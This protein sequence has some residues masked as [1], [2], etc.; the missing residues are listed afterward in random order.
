MK[1][2]SPRIKSS[3]IERTSARRAGWMRLTRTVVLGTVA[4]IAALIWVA[5][6]YGVDRDVMVEFMT[7]SALFVGLLIVAG[8]GGTVVL[9]GLKRCFGRRG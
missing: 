8:L 2:P 3:A 7:T 6:Q 5:D 4:T 9:W 1:R